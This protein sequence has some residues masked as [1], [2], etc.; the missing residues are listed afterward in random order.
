MQD[1]RTAKITDVE[2]FKSRIKNVD[3]K[4]ARD[5]SYVAAAVI[6]T[7]KKQIRNNSNMSYTCG[8]RVSKEGGKVSIEH[9]D[10]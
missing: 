6:Y 1:G 8:K 10:A 7:E 5:F 4:W 3:G 9:H 2:Y